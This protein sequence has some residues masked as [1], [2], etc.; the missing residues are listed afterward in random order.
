MFFAAKN[1]CKDETDVLGCSFCSFI[2]RSSVE[3]WTGEPSVG[4]E[5][6]LRCNDLYVHPDAR[7][8]GL[9][10]MLHDRME[11]F[12]RVK[13]G[14]CGKAPGFLFFVLQCAKGNKNYFEHHLEFMTALETE[15]DE[16]EGSCVRGASAYETSRVMYKMLC[17]E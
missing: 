17:V 16:E 14:D 7:R 6:M 15:D 5:P 10:R 11:K 4:P 8:R 2:F 3:Y 12:G 9:G 1:P 13:M